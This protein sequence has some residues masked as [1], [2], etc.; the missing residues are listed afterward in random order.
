MTSYA[1][2]QPSAPPAN[3]PEVEA[4]RY[5][6]HILN[7]DT[8]PAEFE[9]QMRLLQWLRF[10][11]ASKHLLDEPGVRSDIKKRIQSIA[12]GPRFQDYDMFLRPICRKLAQKGE[13]TQ[14][15]GCA[16]PPISPNLEYVAKGSFGCVYDPALPN[17]SA[18]GESWESYPNN[19]VKFF[20]KKEELN[21]AVES[22]QAIYE[23]LG[24][25]NGH[26]LT[27]Y[28]YQ[29]YKKI[30]IGPKI[31]HCSI[32][33]S[34]ELFLARMPH[35]GWDFYNVIQSVGEQKK[36]FQSIPVVTIGAQVKKLLQQ[37]V[38]LQTKNKIH[39]DIRETNLMMKTDGTM[40]I[41]DFDWLYPKD[42]FFIK[43]F[44]NLGFYNN[45]PESHLFDYMVSLFANKGNLGMIK[46]VIGIATPTKTEYIDNHNR[47]NFHFM[48][49]LRELNLQDLIEA[50]EANFAYFKRLHGGVADIKTFRYN[51]FLE[52]AKT[53]DSFGFA[54]CM[55][56][57]CFRLYI[58]VFESDDPRDIDKEM[59]RNSIK[60]NDVPYTDAEIARVYAFLHALVHQ[61]LRP[62][63][64][65]NIERRKTA[66]TALAELEPLL[67]ALQA[68]GGGARTRRRQHRSK[69]TRRR[70]H[71]K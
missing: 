29:S 1:G 64:D 54:Y 41:V 19:V 46:H 43:Y 13:T 55:L 37:L 48:F 60:N 69:G 52:M 40:T 68:P 42:E 25:N 8:A 26:R 32:L 66:E 11:N 5:A 18:N 53:F 56:E 2:L 49:N 15:P 36:V 39:G 62:M 4:T 51:C 65:W 45:P 44:E 10:I 12:S 71:R 34:K 35:L 28:K 30:N 38:A 23:E 63:A 59:L 21:R 17:I 31:D 20:R 7:I 24:H 57:L 58:S 47:F 27:P 67:V 6:Q 70:H 3:S 33:N 16:P 22:A 50:N 9:R 61:I 14:F